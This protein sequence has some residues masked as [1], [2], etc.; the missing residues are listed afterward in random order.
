MKGKSIIH[1]GAHIRG[2]F[3]TV[4]IGRYCQIG[5]NTILRPPSYQTSLNPQEEEPIKF[6][7]LTIGS[8]T[9]I[10]NNCVIEAAAIGASVYI[11]ENCVIS[12]RVI[13]KDCCY[14]EPGTVIAQDMV[15][16]PFSR[17]RGCP[18]RLVEEGLTPESVAV[19]F[20]EDCVDLFG[21]FVRKHVE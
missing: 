3:Q 4:R 11:G 18:G 10:G 12:K 20:V 7:P 16:P 19:T 5:E 15:I 8:H 13:I 21:D 2:D 9:R 6:L 14:I 1:S 17:V